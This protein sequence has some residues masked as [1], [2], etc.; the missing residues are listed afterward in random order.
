VISTN[1]SNASL[2]RRTTVRPPGTCRNCMLT[3]GLQ[4]GIFTAKFSDGWLPLN[5]EH[6]FQKYLPELREVEYSL[7]E[8][9]TKHG[10]SQRGCRSTDAPQG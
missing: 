6:C 4:P 10:R 7:G 1:G 2:T 3:E 8:L 9:S 5:S